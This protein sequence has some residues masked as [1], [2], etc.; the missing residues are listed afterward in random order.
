MPDAPRIRVSVVYADPD[1]V[2]DVALAL[3]AGATV[4]DAI[5]RSGIHEQRPAIAI[6]ADRLGVFARKV[7]FDTPLRDGDRVEIY[8]PLRIDPKEARRR[9]ARKD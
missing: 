5:S 7:A 9:R 2:F 1:A 4:A 3:P 8:R 6:R